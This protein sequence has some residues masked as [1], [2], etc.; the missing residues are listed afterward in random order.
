M[1]QKEGTSLSASSTRQ[2]SAA[3]DPK[4]SF[5]K[6]TNGTNGTEGHGN[7]VSASPSSF[8]R[9]PSAARTAAAGSDQVLEEGFT[10]G[11]TQEPEQ[12][13]DLYALHRAIETNDTD[14]LRIVLQKLATDEEFGDDDYKGASANGD[15]DDA[16]DSIE[17]SSTGVLSVDTRD[18]YGQTPL[19]YAL[20]FR[21]FEAVR[22]LLEHG[23]DTNISC[24]GATV[25]HIAVKAAGIAGDDQFGIQVVEQLICADVAINVTDEQMRTPFMFA[26]YYGLANTVSGLLAGREARQ[27]EPLWAFNMD[28]QDNHGWTALHWA[29]YGGNPDIVNSLIKEGVDVSLVSK[30]GNSAAHIAAQSNNREALNKLVDCG[31]SMDIENM[32]GFTP[33]HYESEHKNGSSKTTVIHHESSM[34]HLT[35]SEPACFSS[36]DPPPENQ[37][38]LRTLVSQRG[39]LRSPQFS[40]L[41]WNAD[42]QRA[43]ISDILRIHEYSY[44]R[45]LLEAC[46]QCPPGSHGVVSLDGDTTVSRGTWE[47]AQYAAGSVCKAVDMCMSGAT[48]NV[49]CA[50]RPPG[51]H[52][53]PYGKVTNARDKS[54]SHGFC[55]LNNVAIGAAYARA[56][57][58]QEKPFKVA[59]VDFDVHHGNGTEA[60]VEN[61]V[62][63]VRITVNEIPGGE[64]HSK[65]SSYKPWLD[66][67][68]GE[69]VLF[70]SSHGFG[71]REPGMS[72]APH[73]PF[74]YSGSGQNRGH[75]GLGFKNEWGHT[76]DDFYFDEEDHRPSGDSYDLFESSVKRPTVI[77][78]AIPFNCPIVYWKR[79]MVKSILPKLVDFNPDLIFISAG[80]DAHR[81]DDMS[82]GYMG[83][84]EEDYE[85]ITEQLVKVANRC[86]DGKIVSVLE[87]GYR[88]HVS[89]VVVVVYLRLAYGTAWEWMLF[90]G[91]AN[92]CFCN[93]C[94]VPREN[95]V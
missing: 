54:G 65:T 1:N 31:V 42:A 49:F 44:V 80:F 47:A 66:E 16:K 81:K 84:L 63:T 61:L 46:E 14:Q 71:P 28:D 26:C 20:L 78:V 35:C 23:A 17:D 68:D 4:S 18:R 45:K 69:N 56:K 6:D 38:R 93:E 3:A 27:D 83:L 12:E 33:S 94:G 55:L 32:F 70:L 24:D 85:W 95:S 9:S 8:R 2:Q 74:F 52:A 48:E 92:L 50:I 19:H 25:V 34:D 41:S 87:G 13:S 36:I 79:L 77:N 88:I 10:K 22:L 58:S 37:E 29:A 39:I 53:G 91:I 40:G 7:S 59:I 43:S 89:S 51:H 11:G 5:E 62:P 60:C 82:F 57:Y 86:C 67:N 75:P 21:N 72:S 90:A 30:Y 15:E 76:G 73:V 64:L